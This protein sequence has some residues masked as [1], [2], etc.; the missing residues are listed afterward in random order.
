MAVFTAAITATIAAVSTATA[1]GATGAAIAASVATA[2][3]AVSTAVGVAG[4]AVGTIG[5]VIGNE[6]LMF[7]GKIM[8]YVGMGGALAGGVIG[9]LGAVMGNTGLSFTQGAAD[10]FAG[11]SQHISAAWDK[12]VGSF[13]SGGSKVTGA[14]GSTADDVASAADDVAAGAAKGPM[15]SPDGKMAAF[16]EVKDPPGVTRQFIDE[17]VTVAPKPPTA[18]APTINVPTAPNTP[19]TLSSMNTPSAGVPNAP[20]AGTSPTGS[21]L[22]NALSDM[23]DWMK[24]SMMTTGAQGITGL[25]SGYFQ[26]EKAEQEL[27]HQKLIAQRDEAQRQFLNKNA[28]AVPTLRFQTV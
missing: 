5:A 14:V 12:G 28:N 13:F 3:V 7:A 8:G 23:P 10:A 22:A 4:L 9:G 6:D 24:Y 17:G 21:G 19:N 1:V 2:V 27:E 20:V 16:P 15:S 26:G 25:A 11:A 18:P